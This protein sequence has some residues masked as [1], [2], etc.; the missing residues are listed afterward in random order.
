MPKSSQWLSYDAIFNVRATV[1]IRDL[2]SIYHYEQCKE[3]LVRN[4]NMAFTQPFKALC[5]RDWEANAIAQDEI[6]NK[7]LLKGE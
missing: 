4:H 5:K 7:Y 2:Q 3:I 1:T 6:L